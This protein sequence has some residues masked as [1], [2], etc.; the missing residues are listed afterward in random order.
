[1]ISVLCYIWGLLKQGSPNFTYVILNS[2][3]PSFCRKQSLRFFIFTLKHITFC[4]FQTNTVSKLTRLLYVLNCLFTISDLQ[5]THLVQIFLYTIKTKYYKLVFIK[6]CHSLLKWFLVY[7]QII[8][9]SPLISG[10]FHQPTKKHYPHYAQ[11]ATSLNFSP[12][13]NY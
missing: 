13:G 1:M 10:H 12:P 6:I 9:S 7:S 4:L 11:L 3:L 2:S 5:R 8:Q